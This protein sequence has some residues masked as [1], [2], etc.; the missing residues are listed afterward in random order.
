MSLY[1]LTHH[2]EFKKLL[3]PSPTGPND[4]ILELDN[5]TMEKT[6]CL[7][8]FEY[9]AVYGRE[10]GSKDALIY[11]GNIH[12][13]LEH[14]HSGGDPNKV[15]D[16]LSALWEVRPTNPEDWRTLSYAMDSMANYKRTYQNQYRFGLVPIVHEEKEVVEHKFSVPLFDLRLN[17][18]L[19]YP[20][21]LLVEGCADD[22]QPVTFVERLFIHWIGKIDL[23][24]EASDGGLWVADHKTA[25]ITGGS[26]WVQFDLSTQMLGYTYAG[27]KFLDRYIQGAII[28]CVKG[29]KPSR[30]G[31]THV[32]E[33]KR[34]I[35]TDQMVEEW[36]HDTVERVQVVVD[37]LRHGFFSRNTN[38]CSGK[39]SLCQYHRVCV[40]PQ[41]Q[42]ETLLASDVFTDK[43]WSPL[44]EQNTK[45]EHTATI[46]PDFMAGDFQAL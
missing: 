37:A 3:K 15:N 17:Q 4:Y 5:S 42:R 26:Y 13:I 20:K 28:N 7:R 44:L 23:I 46:A 30:T 9:Y 16:L 27:R 21:S 19:K 45:I 41:G 31:D 33:R 11:G 10:G 35:Y 32:C 43:Q 22:D 1:D 6:S 8:A 2:R 40:L 25:S 24:V 29:T 36:Y 12:S 18:D 38:A 39:F 14:L 34:F